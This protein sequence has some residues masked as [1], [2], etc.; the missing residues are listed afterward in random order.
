M[1][2]AD[3]TFDV[4][5]PLKLLGHFVSLS[6]LSLHMS[7]LKIPYE[8]PIFIFFLLIISSGV[9]GVSVR[10]AVLVWFATVLHFA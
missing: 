3:W 6:F 8:G 9:T 7:A 2:I 5:W 10:L 4:A 1:G